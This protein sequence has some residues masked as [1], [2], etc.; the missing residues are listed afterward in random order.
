VKH[1]KVSK[2]QL[3]KIKPVL[4]KNGMEVTSQRSPTR[5]LEVIKENDRKQ[6]QWVLNG[7]WDIYH[8][9]KMAIDKINKSPDGVTFTGI[10]HDISHE[11]NQ[12]LENRNRLEIVIGQASKPD[13]RLGEPELEFEG[14]KK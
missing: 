5:D 12:I 10:C 6:I 11:A 7:L 14:T 8:F 9:A 4:E 3:E 2:E 13:R 1:L